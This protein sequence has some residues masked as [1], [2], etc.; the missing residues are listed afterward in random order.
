MTARSLYAQPHDFLPTAQ[1]IIASNYA[2]SFDAHDDAAFSRMAVYHF[3]IQHA[4]GEK[5]TKTS[6]DFVND[7][8][9]E[10]P[11]II[12]FLCEKYI[13]LHIK[14]KGN[15]PFS[16]ECIAYK[17]LY[18]E[19][20]KTD[21]DRF[22]EA[23][24]KVD[25][26]FD[27]APGEPYFERTADVYQRYLD[28]YQLTEDSKEAMSRAK[29]IKY[30]RRDHRELVLKQKRFGGNPE[31]VFLNIQLKKWDT[32]TPQKPKS[33]QAQIQQPS[34]PAVNEMP[35]DNP[36]DDFNDNDYSDQPDIF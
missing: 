28:F 18:R 2:P 29:V 19:E 30:L 34:L 1:V 15:I 14:L 24:I 6:N 22:F 21:L 25:L 10:F 32:V 23:N 35:E 13:D 31:Q 11:A 8:R 4:R 26:E 3:K 36:F 16:Q 9:P 27:P 17:D 33:V 7:L 12:K 5:D 20:Q